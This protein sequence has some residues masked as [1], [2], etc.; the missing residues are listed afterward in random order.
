MRRSSFE[1][2]RRTCDSL[3][4]KPI[5]GVVPDNQD[6]KLCIDSQQVDF[7][8]TMRELANNG[9]I[10]AQHGYQHVYNHHKTEFSGLPYDEQLQKISIGQKILT[11]K[12]GQTPAWFMAPSHSLDT[13]TCKALCALSFTHITDGIALYPF[14]KHGLTWVPQQLWRPISM[15]FGLWTIC[16]HPNTMNDTQIDAMLEFVKLHAEQFQNIS[17]IPQE[18]LFTIPMRIVW[19]TALFARRLWPI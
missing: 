3:G 14:A 9:W 11:E 4:I 13:T 6:Q 1:R 5:I 16:L 18:S 15:P 8:Q 19:A 7:W 12:I 10:I 2:I 17:L